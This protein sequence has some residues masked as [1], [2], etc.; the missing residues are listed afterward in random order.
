MPPSAL[1]QV[2]E[3]GPQCGET[4]AELPYAFRILRPAHVPII[5]ARLTGVNRRAIWDDIIN[6]NM[7]SAFL[8]SKAV[9]P[10]ML[11]RHWG[12]IINVSSEV[13]RMPMVFTAAHYAAG[14]AGMLGFTRHLAK[15]VASDGI[16]VNATCPG[17]TISDRVR[18]IY[19]TPE[20]IK[21][22][23]AITTIGRL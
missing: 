4:S 20:R 18:R 6:L 1:S 19:D 11:E 2:V 9:L 3:A 17:T 15:E 23:E 12:R 7:R 21:K 16:T 10:G 13:G 5:S 22:L 8:C 14:K